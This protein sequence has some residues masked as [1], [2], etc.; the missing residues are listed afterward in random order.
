MGLYMVT[1][2]SASAVLGCGHDVTFPMSDL[3]VR[4]NMVHFPIC[5][6]CRRVFFSVACVEAENPSPA[7]LERDVAIHTLHKRVSALGLY[8]PN[9]RAEDVTADM[10]RLAKKNAIVEAPSAKH[11]NTRPAKEQP[12]AGATEE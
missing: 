2:D 7:R 1:R 8:M 12:T 5:P 6:M 11:G 10:H 4:K 3:R 9:A